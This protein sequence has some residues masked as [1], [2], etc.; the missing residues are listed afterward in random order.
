[1]SF[2]RLFYIYAVILNLI[3]T[4]CLPSSLDEL[5]RSCLLCLTNLVS[6]LEVEELGGVA[7]LHEMWAKLADMATKQKGGWSLDTRKD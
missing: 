1:M 5:V 7:Q 6:G 3:N 2:K 4:S